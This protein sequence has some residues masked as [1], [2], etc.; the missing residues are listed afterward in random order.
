M[1][2][3]RIPHG[4]P[5]IEGLWREVGELAGKLPGEWVLVG[6][7]MVQLHALEHGVLDVRPTRDIDVLGQARP[8]G[9]LQAIDKTL[10][11]DGFEL[12]RPSFDGY[13]YR[14]ERG[15]LI[16]DV[17]APDGIKPPPAL[18]GG[19]TAIGIPGG[20]QALARSELVTVQVGAGAFNL[21]RPTILGAVLIKARSLMVHSDPAS[22]RE[23]LMRLLSLIDDPRQL[24]TGLRASERK[25]LAQAEG[26]LELS[27][28]S[29]LDADHQR[30]AELAF[31]LLA[32]R[33]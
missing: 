12:V 20:S 13:G 11:A 10:L 32:N 7:L 24:A 15:D 3:I 4:D 5:A 2:T 27:A 19:V 9:A 17:L 26:R 6:G 8:P 25:W 33:T 21:R 18:G 16:V 29:L 22:Q 31:R 14:Y 1:K 30:R 23:D 28:P